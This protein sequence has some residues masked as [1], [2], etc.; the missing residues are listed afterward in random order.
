MLP[1]SMQNKPVSG[2][3]WGSSKLPVEAY[4]SLT[5]LAAGESLLY[6]KGGV[7]F[8]YYEL[9]KPLGLKAE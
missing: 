9:W 6:S 2:T 3:A 5:A 1:E 4:T 7:L 8:F